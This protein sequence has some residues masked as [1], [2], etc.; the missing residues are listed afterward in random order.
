MNYRLIN[1]VTGWLVFAI[2]TA[3]YIL[4]LEP[5][6]SFWDCGEFVSTATNLMIPHPPGAPFFLLIGRLFS[7]FAASP[8]TIA[9]WVNMSSALS[10]SLTVLFLFWSITLLARKIVIA[11]SPAG[12]SIGQICAIMGAGVVGSLAF[13]F[14]DSFWFSSEEAEVYAMSSFFTAFVFWAILKWESVADEAGADRWIILLAYM[15]GLSIGVH[16][17]NL[18][19]LPALAFVYYF[20]KYKA[21]LTG[22]AVTLIISAILIVLVM[23]GIITGLP[24]MASK[25]EVFFVNNLGMGFGS[26]IIF[27]VVCLIA[28]LTAGIVYTI[29]TNRALLNTIL[30]SFAFILIG[31]S[32]YAIIVIRSQFEPTIDMNDPENIMS[33][34]SY[35]KREQYGDRP[36][37]YGPVY[38]AG[39]PESSE[40][41]S[42]IY[43]KGKEKYEIFDYKMK[44]IYN[45]RH[46]MLFPRMYSTQ[47]S[48]VEAYKEIM[49]IKGDHRPSFSKNLGYMFYWQMGHFYFRYFFWNFVSRAGSDYGSGAIPVSEWFNKSEPVGLAKGKDASGKE[50]YFANLDGSIPEML[51][52]DKARNN[53]FAI[54][55]ILGLIG[56]FYHF[57]KDRNYAIINLMFF[58]FT[59]LA[60]IIYLNQ[61]PIEPRER[62]YT[63]VG[64]FYAFSIWIGLGVLALY[65]LMNKVMKSMPASL[66][67]TLIGL[68]VPGILM[69]ENWDDH[70]RSKRYHSVDSAKNLLN[71]C[72][73]NA[74]L[75][76]GGDN[77]TYPLWYAQEVEK[78]RR[79]VRVCN[80]SLLNTDWYINQMRRRSYESDPLPISIK[81]ENYLSGTNDIIYYYNARG[82]KESKLALDLRKY[83][84]AVNNRKGSVTQ[85]SGGGEAVTIYPSKLMLLPVDKNA[86]LQKGI[87]AENVKSYVQDTILWNIPGNHFDKKTLIIL[88]MI[89]N[90][91]WER[92]IYFSTTLSSEDYLNLREYMQ[93]EGLAYRLLPVKVPGAKYGWINSD[94][95]Q[96]NMMDFQFRNLTDSTIYY[97]ENFLRFPANARNQYHAL[98]SQLIAEGKNDKAKEVVNH[99]LK[100]MPDA[101]VPYDYYMPPFIS[102]LYKLGEASK[103][104]EIANTMTRRAVQS[105]EYQQAQG[106]SSSSRDYQMNLAYLDQIVNAYREAGKNEEANLVYQTLMKYYSR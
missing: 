6:G 100:M 99:C 103:A 75:F 46:E 43:R 62:D 68:I 41:E 34:V 48:H 53:Y 15:V 83:L 25:V 10:S 55:L 69:A 45:K 73:K 1:N 88:D 33:F 12:Y 51:G 16:L 91:N 98:A 67:A 54:P 59:G 26:G 76:T 7:L 78:V 44:Y 71:S 84:Q 17:L 22:I 49:D 95:M 61:P 80:L 64:S 70:D 81:E 101:A 60:L 90:N 3:V 8:E 19:A 106:I 92:P 105:L 20:K 32:S 66:L 58:F 86:V 24:S 14:T 102:L 38:T 36:L 87:I 13:A 30:L 39:Y 52:R 2:A 63:H 56:L 11:D 77:D 57:S 9:Y 35:L 65:D 23:N 89:V 47:P 28:L 40:R 93:L 18:V 50:T 37:L 94:I 97:D 74:I 42:P 4:T 82:E 96:K 85:M 104:D 5:T 72:A 27:F 29:K 21:N 79:D 31:Y